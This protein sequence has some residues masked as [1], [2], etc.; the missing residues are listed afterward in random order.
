M[1]ASRRASLLVV[2]AHP[3]D[4]IFHGGMLMH[5]S[6]RGVRVTLVCATNGEAGKT[7]PSIGA[8][9][10]IGELRIEELT[11]VLQQ[12][13]HRRRRCSSAFTIPRVVSASG[14]TTLARWRTWT[15]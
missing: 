14:T 13:R 7:H 1:T 15:C 3:D 2:F 8:V 6:Q 4:E 10:D 12:A 5:L 11:G 9:D